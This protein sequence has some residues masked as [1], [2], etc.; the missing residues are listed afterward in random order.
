M[1]YLQSSLAGIAG[2]IVAAGLY[3]V[4]RHYLFVQPNLDIDI[5]DMPMWLLSLVEPRFVVLF[6]RVFRVALP[7]LL[8]F[9][10][11]FYLEF[12]RISSR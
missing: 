1:I 12:R 9:A 6:V 4:S 5:L 7:A 2:V 8:I 3:L 11:C 10:A